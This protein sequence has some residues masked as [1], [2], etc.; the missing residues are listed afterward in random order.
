MHPAWTT[1]PNRVGGK[2]ESVT[3]GRANIGIRS[4][5]RKADWEFGEIVCSNKLVDQRSCRRGCTAMLVQGFAS[6]SDKL[7]PQSRIAQQIGDSMSK[8]SGRIDLDL[9]RRQLSCSV[10]N[11]TYRRIVHESACRRPA[12]CGIDLPTINHAKGRNR[13]CADAVHFDALRD[14]RTG[15]EN[16]LLNH[17]FLSLRASLDRRIGKRGGGRD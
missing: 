4:P 9:F 15:N 1:R 16:R 13:F 17:L 6:I 3:K 14:E 7:L 8:L 12:P 5:S 10:P 11:D 2:S